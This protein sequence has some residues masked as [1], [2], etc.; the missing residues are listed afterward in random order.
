VKEGC[1]DGSATRETQNLRVSERERERES[2]SE[3]SGTRSARRQSVGGLVAD[4]PLT[5]G[6][7]VCLGRDRWSK[8]DGVV[9]QILRHKI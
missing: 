6:K 3:M 2:K 5:F 8:R 1:F 7:W 9:P 4:A